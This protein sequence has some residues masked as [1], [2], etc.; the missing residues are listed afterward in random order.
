MKLFLYC[1]DDL[2]LRSGGWAADRSSSD[3]EG[4][5]LAV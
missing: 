3:W 2:L 5:G 4:A 1:G